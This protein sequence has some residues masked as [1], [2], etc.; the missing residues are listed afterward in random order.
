[1]LFSSLSC[2]SALR[3]TTP[4]QYGKDRYNFAQLHI[5]SGSEHSL[6]GGH[7]DAELHLVHRKE[8][9][10]AG[11]PTDD[12]LVIGVF[13][14]VQTAYKGDNVLVAPLFDAIIKAN[15]AEMKSLKSGKK[16]EAAPP[17]AAADMST[18]LTSPYE[19][20]PPAPEHF[21]SVLSLCSSNDSRHAAAVTVVCCDCT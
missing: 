16:E 2:C 21:R 1:V 12:L 14:D 5:H 19:L 15:T 10:V 20:L 6:A 18:M 11:T 17:A 3:C 8:G 13:L 7:S 9:A 4:P